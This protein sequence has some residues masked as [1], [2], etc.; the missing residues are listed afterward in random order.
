MK[1]RSNFV[2]N[3]SSSSF[4]IETA[5]IKTIVNILKNPSS[6]KF[7]ALEKLLEQTYPEFSETFEPTFL[8]EMNTNPKYNKQFY[9]QIGNIINNLQSAI[10]LLP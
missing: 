9:K 1:I 5:D 2:S 6:E 10:L 3:S 4:I 7:K 8:K